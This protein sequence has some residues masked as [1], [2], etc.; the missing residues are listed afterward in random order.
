MANLELIVEI[1][2]ID[3]QLSC[4]NAHSL[5]GQADILGNEVAQRAMRDVLHQEEQA[6]R[7]LSQKNK[8]S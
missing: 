3:H 5:D 8:Q 1:L 4:V 2:E 6:L 7:I